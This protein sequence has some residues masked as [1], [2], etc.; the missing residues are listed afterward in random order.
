MYGVQLTSGSYNTISYNQLSDCDGFVEADDLHQMNTSN[1]IEYNTLLFVYGIG[2]YGSGLPGY[3]DLTCGAS[4]YGFN[5]SGNTCS[6]NVVSGSSQA[7][8]HILTKVSGGASA[9]YVNNTCTQNCS[10]F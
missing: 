5:Y 2:W 9:R 1:L 3:N 10:V 8:A 7:S 6:G 4:P